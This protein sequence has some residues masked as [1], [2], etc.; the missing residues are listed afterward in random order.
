VGGIIYHYPALIEVR[1][2]GRLHYNLG[3]TATILKYYQKTVWTVVAA[4]RTVRCLSKVG[5]II[6]DPDINKK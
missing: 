5:G 1:V 6:T 2:I 3:Q 4:Y